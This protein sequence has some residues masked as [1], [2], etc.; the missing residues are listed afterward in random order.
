MLVTLILTEQPAPKKEREPSAYQPYKPYV[1]YGKPGH[2]YATSSYKAYQ[3]YKPYGHPDHPYKPVQVNQESGAAPADFLERYRLALP[4]FAIV[5]RSPTRV[6]IDVDA[7]DAKILMEVLEAASVRYTLDEDEIPTECSLCGHEF[8]PEDAKKG[9]CP[10]CLA[11]TCDSCGEMYS[12][13]RGK[14]PTCKNKPAHVDES[15]DDPS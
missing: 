14:C 2:Q 11:K 13:K 5:K 4:A 7:G 6:T 12:P 3:P 9:R 8:A 1:P 10:K 15:E